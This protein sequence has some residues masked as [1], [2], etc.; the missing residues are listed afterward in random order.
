MKQVTD[1]LKRPVKVG[2]TVLTKGYMHS[3][4]NTISKVIRVNKNTIS[5]NL[6]FRYYN[7]QTRSSVT[8]YKIMLR[9][10]MSF[11]VI[12]EQIAYNNKEYPEYYV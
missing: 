9:D 11:V 2:D 3:A 10:P 8:G 6:P 1:I 5:V 12:D 7:Y 4:I